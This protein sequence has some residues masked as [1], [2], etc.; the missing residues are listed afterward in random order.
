[1]LGIYVHIP[2]CKQ[3]C[4]YCDFNSYPGIADM[5]SSYVDALMHEIRS[6]SQSG[7]TVDTIYIGGG[8][9]TFIDDK[10]IAEIMNVIDLCY[11]ISK[12]AEITVECNPGTADFEKLTRL[13][14]F[15]INRLSIGCQSSNDNIL[16]YIGRIHTYAEF[17]ECFVSAR[18][19]GFD[20]ISVDLMFGLPLQNSDIWLD[21]LQKV[22][23][24]NPEHISAYS[25]KIEEKTPFYSMLE[26]NELIVPNDDQN[27][28]MYDKAVQYLNGN[29]Y[30]RYEISNFSKPG[31]ESKHN[32]KY[33]QCKDYIGFGA[34]AYSC[35]DGKRFSNEY[36]IHRYISA[37]EKNGTAEIKDKT[38]DCSEN[39]FMSEFM[40]LGLRLDSGVSKEDFK[41]RFGR[42]VYDVFSLPLKKHTD[43]TKT[44]T[45]NGTHIKIKPEYMYVSN[46]IMSDFIL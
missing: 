26:N 37:T 16:K 18:R 27:R 14:N 1:M 41:N 42:S 24:L 10:Y 2:F 3:K 31:Y 43:K 33:W 13:K 44:I 21:T 17:V 7:R 22:T 4:K 6:C 36:N 28:D 25:L 34:G 45:D 30:R 23:A 15:G 29:G 32:L 11:N 39:D 12:D 40:F 35:I 9:P 20:N 38:I 5:S 46:I 19:A 8:T